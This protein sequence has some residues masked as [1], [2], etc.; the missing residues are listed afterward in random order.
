M[1]TEIKKLDD[2]TELQKKFVQALKSPD[3]V[4]VP[5]RERWRWAATAAGYSENTT[6]TEITAPIRHLIKDV[7]EQIIAEASIAAAW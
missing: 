3:I 7:A 6:V 2:C 4:E 1:T 5:R